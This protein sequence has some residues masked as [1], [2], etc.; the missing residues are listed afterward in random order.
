M[1]R[2]QRRMELIGITFLFLFLYPCSLF[3]GWQHNGQD[4]RVDVITPKRGIIAQFDAGQKSGKVSRRYV[5]AKPNEPFRVRI[6]N[7]Y[8]RRIGVVIAIDGRN[9]ISG[10][11]S[12]LKSHERMYLLNPYQTQEFNGWRTGKN[13]INTFY[14]TSKDNSYAAHRGDESAMGVIAV[15]VFHEKLKPIT[16]PQPHNDPSYGNNGFRPFTK[17]HSSRRGPGTGIGAGSWSPS[18]EVLFTAKKQ[19][20]Q[21]IFIKYEWRK[22][23]CQK[24]IVQCRPKH[25]AH[26]NNHNRFWPKETKKHRDEYSGYVPFPLWLLPPGLPRL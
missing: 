9:I 2:R 13:Q 12:H 1:N 16:T 6:Y 20:S 10:K 23:L 24:G 3:A 14:F 21:K 8:N 26:G 15:A 19:P 7:P 5:I 11:Q 18:H 17:S 22:S 4:V 25:K